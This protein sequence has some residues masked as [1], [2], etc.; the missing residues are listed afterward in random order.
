MSVGPDQD[1]CS[2]RIR[3]GSESTHLARSFPSRV[4]KL[5]D[6]AKLFAAAKDSMFGT[7][8]KIAEIISSRYTKWVKYRTDQIEF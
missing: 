2:S 7:T 5:D 8:Y 1:T 6:L 3:R 4:E